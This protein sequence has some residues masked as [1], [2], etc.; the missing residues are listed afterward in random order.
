VDRARKTVLRDRNHPSIVLWSAGT[1]SGSGE[2]ICASVY[3][4]K[5]LRLLVE[6]MSTHFG[7]FGSYWRLSF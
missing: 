2:N 1:E 6:A 7:P 4:G 3:D 5:E